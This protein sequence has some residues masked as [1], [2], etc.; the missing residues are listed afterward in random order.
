[1]T[2]PTRTWSIHVHPLKTTIGVHSNCRI[3][4][5]TASTLLSDTCSYNNVHYMLMFKLATVSMGNMI[6]KV[7]VC[8]W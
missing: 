6:R 4:I 8:V 7:L 5:N 2:V 1:M 3:S